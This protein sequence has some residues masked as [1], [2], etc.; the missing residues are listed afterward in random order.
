LPRTR[1]LTITLV[2]CLIVVYFYS[3]VEYVKQRQKQTDIAVRINDSS[4]AL[5]LL[6]QVPKDLKQRLEAAQLAN[7]LAKEGV[8]PGEVNTTD[9][10]STVFK[11]ADANKVTIIPFSTDPWREKKV[12]S[13][14]FLVFRLSLKVEGNYS[15]LLGFIRQLEE[16]DFHSMVIE[17]L[18]VTKSETG[19][20]KISGM[21]DLA[22]YTLARDT[23]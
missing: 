1:L 23:E 22:L 5:S 17:S 11:A 6:P 8:F 3:G 4:R 15:G 21:V 16:T 14:V 9:V 13:R 12:E 19:T 7:L 2:V 10:I 20:E 18:D